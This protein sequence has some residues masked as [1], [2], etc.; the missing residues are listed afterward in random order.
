MW[1]DS[2]EDRR[3]KHLLSTDFVRCFS[4][5]SLTLTPILGGNI[6]YLQIGKWKLKLAT[7]LNS[8]DKER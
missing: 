2:L 8:S 1:S 4:S 6:L 7:Y 5:R 3:M